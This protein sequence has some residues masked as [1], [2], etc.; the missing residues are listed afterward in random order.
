MFKKIFSAFSVLVGKIHWKQRRAITETQKEQIMEMLKENYYVICTRRSNH[1]S[2]YAIAIGHFFLTG[3]FGRYGHVLLN[4]EDDVSSEDDFRL[5]EAVGVGTKFSTFDE[6]FGD[7]DGVC[8][9][10]PKAMTIDEWT[11][12]LDVAKSQEGKP[13]DTLFDMKNDQA[14]SCVE[15]VRL[16]LKA[17]PHYNVDFANF[18]AMVNKRL[19]LTPQMFRD[20]SDFEPVLEIRR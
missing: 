11:G 10:K 19:N 1:L 5:V 4:L 16:I 14:L 2:T 8:L 20:C 12:L 15:L 9:L 17:S 13:Y 6:V 7:V 3:K 18:E